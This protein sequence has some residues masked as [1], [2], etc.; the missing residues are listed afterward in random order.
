MKCCVFMRAI[1]F[2]C[3][4][5][6]I[7]CDEAYICGETLTFREPKAKHKK[8]FKKIYM[9]RPPPGTAGDQLRSIIIVKITFH[10]NL[11]IF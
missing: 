10:R 6:D 4:I 1:K 9:N 2:Y 3:A 5:R 8:N 7:M 11:L